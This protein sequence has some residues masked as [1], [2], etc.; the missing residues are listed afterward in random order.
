MPLHGP[1]CSA[2]QEKLSELWG[3]WQTV[4]E[5]GVGNYLIVAIDTQLR[6]DFSKRGANVYFKDVQARHTCAPPTGG[7]ARDGDAIVAHKQR[8]HPSS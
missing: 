7:C 2:L 8:A 4:K 5:A 3:L 6:D 1:A